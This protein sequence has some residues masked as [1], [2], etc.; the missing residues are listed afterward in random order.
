[1]FCDCLLVESLGGSDPYCCFPFSDRE[2]IGCSESGFP[3]Y[4]EKAGNMFTRSDWD[5]RREETCKYSQHFQEGS[6][7]QSEHGIRVQ[8]WIPFFRINHQKYCVSMKVLF[9]WAW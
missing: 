1:M 3:Q 7:S 8:L 2:T 5:R 9:I 6:I 4:S